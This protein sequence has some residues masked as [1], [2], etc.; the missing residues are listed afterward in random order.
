MQCTW[1]SKD[2]AQQII[3][4]HELIDHETN[5]KRK[6][7]LEKVLDASNRLYHDTFINF[8]KPK[9]TAKQRLSS[10]LDSTLFYGRYYSIVKEFFSTISEHIDTIDGISSKLEKTPL[11]VEYI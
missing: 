6:L 9:V 11:K 7:Y 8:S 1:D 3:K 2:F 5:L 10:I 4:L